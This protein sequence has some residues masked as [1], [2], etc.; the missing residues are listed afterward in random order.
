[1]ESIAISEVRFSAS[2]QRMFVIRV[3]MRASMAQMR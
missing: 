1:M 3:R 2:A